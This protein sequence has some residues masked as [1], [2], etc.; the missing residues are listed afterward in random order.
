MH[1][2][3][4]RGD[5][6]PDPPPPQKKKNHKNIGFHS[7]TGPDPLKNHKATKP[8]FNAG[9]SSA[10]QGNANEMA[11]RW[12]PD[13]GP[14]T[15]V[16]GSSLLSSTEKNVV[17]VGPPLTKLSGYVH[18]LGRSVACDYGIPGHSHLFFKNL[19]CHPNILLYFIKFMHGSRGGQGVWTPPPPH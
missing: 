1:G 3:I 7:N 12:R 17:K 14:L 6:G 5:R 4:Q 11:F 19:H 8:G 10:K 9:P 15:V 16:F 13:G 18:A 2:R